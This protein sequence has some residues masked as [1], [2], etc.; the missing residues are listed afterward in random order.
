MVLPEEGMQGI[1][2]QLLIVKQMSLDTRS[3]AGSIPPM[4]LIRTLAM[5]HWQK[6]HM[7]IGMIILVNTDVFGHLAVCVRLIRRAIPKILLGE[8]KCGL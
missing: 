6:Q 2:W 4:L 3:I 8:L 5:M 1:Q 7:S